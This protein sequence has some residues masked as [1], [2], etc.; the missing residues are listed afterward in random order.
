MISNNNTPK[1]SR[2]GVGAINDN[3]TSE[4]SAGKKDFSGIRSIWKIS[5]LLQYNM[6][7]SGRSRL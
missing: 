3:D 7:L 1:G 2:D 5:L 6:V 4:G